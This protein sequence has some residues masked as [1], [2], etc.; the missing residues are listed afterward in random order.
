MTRQKLSAA[1][2]LSAITTAL[3]LSSCATPANRIADHPEIYN[4]LNN[5]DRALVAEGKIRE[6]MSKDAVF[7]AWG[8]PQQTSVANVRGKPADTWVYMG[9]TDA[10]P[11]YPGPYGFGYGFGYGGAAYPVVVGRRGNRHI[12]YY[13][14]P[15]YWN[16]PFYYQPYQRISYPSRTVSFQN[17]R[18]VAYQFL[19]PPSV[20]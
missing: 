15:F 13:Y 8:S 20:Y 9:Y 6:G 18:V 17:E 7:L 4:R 1:L 11:R 14:D 10:Y 5:T 2:F 12:G 3:L 16:D 19:Y